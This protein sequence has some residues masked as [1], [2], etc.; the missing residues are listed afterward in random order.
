MMDPHALDDTF[1]P[2]EPKEVRSD[3][4]REIHTELAKGAAELRYPTRRALA[5]IS[6]I[7]T[8]SQLLKSRNAWRLGERD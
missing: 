6:Q 7:K 8:I 5:E 3:T 2:P 1:E 4:P